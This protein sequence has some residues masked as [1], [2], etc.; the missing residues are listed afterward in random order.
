MADRGW[1]RAFD[2][3]ILLPDGRELVTL[4][5]A[6]SYII[7]TLPKA[8]QHHPAWLA[9]GKALLLV[10]EHGGPTMLAR[11]GMMRA[12]NAGK[13]ESEDHAAPQA[14]QSLQD[15]EV[16]ALAFRTPPMRV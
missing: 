3:P 4:E 12:L 8:E 2:E 16:T 5:D 15:R 1:K 7:G 10:A 9:A 13:P 14:R 11:I 6:G